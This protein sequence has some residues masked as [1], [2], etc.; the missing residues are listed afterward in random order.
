MIS[1]TISCII[2]L[3][4]FF[5][6]QVSKLEQE[7]KHK[8]R[9][10]HADFKA[11][12]FDPILSAPKEELHQL[13]IGLYGEHLLPATMYEIEKV[14]RSPDTI[15]GYDK[16]GAAMYV[17]SKTRL[18]D[19]YARLRNRL[20]SVDSSTSTIEI[21]T[22]YA[23]HF[24]DMYIKK[25]DGKHMM[26]DCMKIL[27]LNLPFLLRD[28]IEPEASSVLPVQSCKDYWLMLVLIHVH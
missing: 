28:L 13:L 5:S 14:L 15:S 12:D 25:H 2:F 18:K 23:A 24:Y 26:G 10:D 19:V 3:I 1:D 7:L 22:D 20:S 17:I 8:L 9:P 6:I 11:V 27:M 16:N 21:S 4:M